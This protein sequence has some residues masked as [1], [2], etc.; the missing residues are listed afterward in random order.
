MS[1][2]FSVKQ[3]CTYAGLDTVITSNKQEILNADGLILPGVG[4][5]GSVMANLDKLDLIGPIKDFTAQGKPLAGIC[6]GMQLLFTESEEMGKHKGLNILEGSVLSFNSLKIS[7]EQKIRVPYIGW[8]TIF[9]PSKASEANWA[10]SPLMS[11]KRNDYMYF[12]HSFCCVPQNKEEI[13]SVTDYE[14]IIY[15][16]SVLK[17]NIFACQFHPEKSGQQGLTIYRNLKIF[18]SGGSK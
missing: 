15:C 10:L 13:L 17:G 5:F 18:L 11:V 3:A 6:L 1:N 4:A 16:S 9:P 14:G 12:V 7:P 8:N 2:L